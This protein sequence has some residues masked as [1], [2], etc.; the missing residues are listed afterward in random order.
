L[1]QDLGHPGCNNEYLIKT[2]SEVA[3][4]YNHRSVLENCHSFMLC[5]M[6]DKRDDLNILAGL[7]KDDKTTVK[8]LLMECILST[9]PGAEVPCANKLSAIDSIETR[10]PQHRLAIM[11]CIVKM[12]DVSNVAR[13]W[14][15]GFWWSFLA[16]EEAFNQGDAL[17]SCGIPVPVWVDRTATTKE[18]NSKNLIDT[19]TMPLFKALGRLAPKFKREVGSILAENR[20][21]WVKEIGP[22]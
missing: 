12:A 4:L 10:V 15:V 13:D 6:M 18:R 5:Q 3:A 14:D 16:A 20:R 19:M 7:S 2:E 8:T 11:Q 21:K 17:K 9:D 22:T 1:C